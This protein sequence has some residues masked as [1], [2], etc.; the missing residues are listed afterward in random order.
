M[1]SHKFLRRLKIVQGLGTKQDTEKAFYWYSKSA[2]NGNPHAQEEL[3]H[4]YLKGI[5]TRID[6]I[7]AA[8]WYKEAA[9]A[10]EKSEA[11]LCL[12]KG[13]FPST[14]LL[15]EFFFFTILLI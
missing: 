14:I 7:S 6:L 8:K 2:Q 15:L 13:K 10:P 12:N 11:R 3:G 9:H 5:G 4:C 1:P